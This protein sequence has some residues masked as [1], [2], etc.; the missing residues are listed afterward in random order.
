MANSSPDLFEKQVSPKSKSKRS[1]SYLNVT[2]G[3]SDDRVDF[4]L[5]VRWLSSPKMGSVSQKTD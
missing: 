2:R 5:L 4:D 3:V 1:E